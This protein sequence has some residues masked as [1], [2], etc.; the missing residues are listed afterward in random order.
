M[1]SCIPSKTN[2]VTQKKL[3]VAW[4]VYNFSP[5]S[6]T[7]Y[8]IEVL[9]LVYIRG[10]VI[11]NILYFSEVIYLLWVKNLLGK[12][13]H[14]MIIS[15]NWVFIPH[16]DFYQKKRYIMWCMEYFDFF[17]EKVLKILVPFHWN[18]SVILC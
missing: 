7:F 10:D 8:K 13:L 3:N 4:L 15:D 18:A 11:L 2:L 14:I 9:N 17:N 5:S 16:N 6:S 1:S 12:P